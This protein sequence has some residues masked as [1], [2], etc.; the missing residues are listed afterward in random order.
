MLDLRL[1]AEDPDLIKAHLRRRFADEELFKSV[2]SV[3]ALAARRRELVLERDDLRATRNSLSKAIGALYKEGKRDEAEAAKAEVVAGN[4]RIKI[5]EDEL[6]RVEG[7]ELD[8]ALHIP[9]L[10]HDDV[11]D[12]PDEAANIELRRVGTPRTFDPPALAHVEVGENLGLLDLERSAK[13]SGARFSVLR[14]PLAR[15]ERALTNYFLDLHTTKH[16]Y[17]ELVVPY[18]V[19]AS[20]MV[21][22][23][24][25]PKFGDDMF[26]LAEPVNGQDMYLIPTAE[27]PLTNMHSEEILEEKTLPLKYV[28][29]TPC[30]RAEA[31]SAGR[32]VRGLIRQHQFHKVELVWVT[33]PEN[34]MAAHES[35]LDHAET[36]LKQLELPYRVE[37]LSAGDT[38][39]NAHKCYDL[40]VWLPSQAA[41][42]EV[43]S[44]SNFWDFQ[45]RRMNMRYRPD[46]GDGK[47]HKPRFPHTINGSGLAVGRTMV[48]LLENGQQADGSVDLPEVLWGYMGGLKRLEREE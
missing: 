27:V 8:H 13:L 45:A 25:L 31:G 12:G 2:D 14:G 5:L 29:F 20:A 17:T 22:T 32:D 6:G 3:V 42:R 34:S 44:V 23:G 15:L 21:G 33:R 37:V 9:N 11:P 1:I 26:K 16:G 4:E 10:L 7:Q 36:A 35:L 47:K 46:P 40:E 41:Y 28:A 39:A 48:A 30:F 43:S 19:H 18:M 24:Q 38:S